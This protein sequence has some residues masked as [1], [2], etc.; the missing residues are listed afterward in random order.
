MM[1]TL[2]LSA[3]CP[4]GY[5]RSAMTMGCTA[6]SDVKPN[7]SRRSVKIKRMEIK[8]GS[9][10]ASLPALKSAQCACAIRQ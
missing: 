4:M 2:N 9:A 3:A 7:E 10:F 1:G 8:F 6:E 5:E